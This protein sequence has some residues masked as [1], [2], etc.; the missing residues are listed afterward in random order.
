[1]LCRYCDGVYA[2]A[3]GPGSGGQSGWQQLILHSH[4]TEQ[5]SL[6]VPSLLHTFQPGTTK[7][8]AGIH[9]CIH[10]YIV[11]YIHY[12]LTECLVYTPCII[13]C[14]IH[15][16]IHLCVVRHTLIYSHTTKWRCRSGV[17]LPNVHSRPSICI[18]GMYVYTCIIYSMLDRQCQ[19]KNRTISMLLHFI[20]LCDIYSIPVL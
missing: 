10:T 11:Y 7:L 17:S 13:A 5:L 4:L 3:S 6:S 18:R 15:V 14:Y 12:S 8:V 20:I 9:M 19:K 1:M 16:Y 2:A